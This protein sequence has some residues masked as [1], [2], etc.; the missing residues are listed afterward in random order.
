MRVY[1]LLA[2]AG[3]DS[4]RDN[5]VGVTASNIDGIPAVLIRNPGVFGRNGERLANEIVSQIRNQHPTLV[6]PNAR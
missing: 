1:M 4:D 2:M 3:N 5:P 6:H